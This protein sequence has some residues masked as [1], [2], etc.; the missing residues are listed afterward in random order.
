VQIIVIAT[1]CAEF[2]FMMSEAELSNE[3]LLL[4]GILLQTH[5]RPTMMSHM[6]IIPISNSAC[7][8]PCCPFGAWIR[9]SLRSDRQVLDTHMTHIHE[10]HEHSTCCMAASAMKTAQLNTNKNRIH[11]PAISFPWSANGIGSSA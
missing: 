5:A 6:F 10:F 9:I 1:A 7:H 3:I 8:W 11:H 2:Q 4:R